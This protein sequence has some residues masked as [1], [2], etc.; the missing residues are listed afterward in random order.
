[1]VKD[2]NKDEKKCT[3][4]VGIGIGVMEYKFNGD[5]VYEMGFSKGENKKTREI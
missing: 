2:C 5:K 1:M 3:I 4:D